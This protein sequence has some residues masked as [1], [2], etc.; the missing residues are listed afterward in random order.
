MRTKFY[1]YFAVVLTVLLFTSIENSF[2][3]CYVI[4]NVDNN[5]IV[6]KGTKSECQN[7]MK[8]KIS[9]CSRSSHSMS[10][11]AYQ[12]LNSMAGSSQIRSGLIKACEDEI[13]RSYRI[14][15]W[16][17][18]DCNKQ[19]SNNAKKEEKTEQPEQNPQQTH[20]NEDDIKYDELRQTSNMA[21]EQ[22][23]EQ[24][25]QLREYINNNREFEKSTAIETGERPAMTNNAVKRPDRSI[26]TNMTVRPPQNRQGVECN[27]A[28]T[29]EK[30][31]ITKWAE[32]FIAQW[33]EYS[34]WH[35]NDLQ[36]SL[37]EYA[38]YIY[39]EYNRNGC[40]HREEDFAAFCK[41]LGN[42]T[43]RLSQTLRETF[44]TFMPDVDLSALSADVY[45]DG[46]RAA[47]W[48]TIEK[49]DWKSG[50]YATL[51]Q[52][53]YDSTIYVLAFR[54]TEPTSPK[55][56]STDA[57]LISNTPPTQYKLAKELID[58]VLNH[59]QFKDNKNK[60]YLTGHSLGGGLA[61]YAHLSANSPSRIEATYTYNSAG[62]YKEW[63]FID[64]YIN[65]CG[66]IYAFK[67][68]NEK[69]ISRTHSGAN[70]LRHVSIP[71]WIK[72]C[73]NKE[74]TKLEV[75]GIKKSIPIATGH[76]IDPIAQYYNTT[77]GVKI[78]NHQF[79][80]DEIRNYID[81][82]LREVNDC[83]CQYR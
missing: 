10:S 82:V 12:F 18:D 56:L 49:Y 62:I 50:F 37:R 45:N 33:I 29:I 72:I 31:K 76:P 47:G 42:E 35:S 15:L 70:I 9:Y 4:R 71:F 43:A 1:C 14:E 65:Y 64:N 6:F 39:D 80:V 79:S 46:Y 25:K 11:S 38:L 20:Y 73:V 51:Y 7:E 40:D 81:N 23:A 3:Q 34:D 36:Q 13:K 32:D 22:K 5:K 44:C 69:L 68:N 2:A 41:K 67:T 28:G 8:R 58:K 60:L 53:V 78:N 83:S 26:T 30:E 63:I 54:G 74:I 52:N 17:N 75:I 55:D 16:S 48:R 21:I 27:F 66:N 77:Y 59:P 24:G 19:S 57:S 61:S